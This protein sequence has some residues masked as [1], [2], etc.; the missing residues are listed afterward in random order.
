MEP[1]Q[2]LSTDFTEIRY[3][4]GTRKAHLM[5]VVDVG[6]AWVPGWAVGSSAEG[7][8]DPELWV[9]VSDAPGGSTPG[10]PNSE[11]NRAWIEQLRGPARE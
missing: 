10:T 8:N 11:E 1:L 5:A 9:I 6:S 2:A 3:A 4:G 7:V